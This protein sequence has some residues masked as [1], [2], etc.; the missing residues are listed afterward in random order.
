[1]ISDLFRKFMTSATHLNRQQWFLVLIGVVVLGMFFLKGFG[2][3]K[4]Y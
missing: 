4:N 1:M 2:S 3:R